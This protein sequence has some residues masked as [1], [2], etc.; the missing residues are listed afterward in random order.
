M[1]Q[2]ASVQ[3]ATYDQLPAA[4]RSQADSAN[5]VS[6]APSA[7]AQG[8]QSIASVDEDSPDTIKVN[9]PETFNSNT[10]AQSQTLGHEATHLMENNRPPS[11]VASIPKDDPNKP[12]DISD[13]EDL[14]SKGKTF[15]DLP[16]EKAATVIQKYIASGGKDASLK[17]WVK[18]AA[19]MKQST[20]MPTKPG[21][22]GIET[23]ARAPRGGQEQLEELQESDVH[24][25]P[26][27]T[28]AKSGKSWYTGASALK[29]N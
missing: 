21:Q 24:N 15:G 8:L 10:N 13:L 28:V 17:Q 23:Q 14:R 22:Q 27:K 7:G 4:V 12:Y 20:V 3:P 25:P 5:V 6:G 19:Q 2:P 11:E 26:P 16:Q 29:G 9:D 18:E 1:A